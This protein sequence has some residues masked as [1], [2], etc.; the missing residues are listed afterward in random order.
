M[1][2]KVLLQDLSESL[3]RRRGMDKED[4]NVFVR[5]VFDI[6]AE[7]LQADKIIK[8]KGLGTFK[9]VTV[10][11]RESVDVNTGERIVIKEYTKVNFTPDPVLR[12]A[13]NKPFAQFET[14][15]LYEGTDV[16]E[17][18]RMDFPDEPELLEEDEEVGETEST[19]IANERLP[20]E[21][22]LAETEET[23][24]D[25]A[26]SGPAQVETE[27]AEEV[28]VNE[29]T[30]DSMSEPTEEADDIPVLGNPMD[31][32][33]EAEMDV[34]EQNNGKTEEELR[35]KE[36]QELSQVEPEKQEQ[37]IDSSAREAESAGE[38]P[39]ETKEDDKAQ[40]QDGMPLSSGEKTDDSPDDRQP[41]STTMHVATQQ[42]EV[43]KVEHQN[44]EHQHI[45]QMVPD[46][47]TRRIYLTPWMIFFVSLVVLVLMSFSYYLGYN[48]FFME[49]DNGD[50]KAVSAV[51]QN[52]K[53]QPVAAKTAVPDTVQ[54]KRD[55]LQASSAPE[56]GLSKESEKAEQK[57]PVEKNTPQTQLPQVKG[58]AYEIIGTREEHRLKRGETLREIAL[59][60]YG[61]KNFT[62]YLVTY[63]N[64]VNPD[65]VPEGMLLKI[66]ELKLKHR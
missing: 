50:A 26:K 32:M 13:V 11:S 59:R 7:Y 51:R 54:V 45:V 2:K 22:V 29:Q 14:V 63:N 42:I 65:L 9:L 27:V 16:A 46:S 8:V 3:V 33:E 34:Q 53:Q 23:A 55:T 10:D 18:E 58:G 28:V 62:V 57:Q 47:G 17:M 61:S 12:D 19:A 56:A 15:V 49:A 60:Y 25:E 35:S 37:K 36:V 6:I 66:P 1:N 41:Q 24:T 31:R 52:V 5:S 64:I 39:E 20:Q 48:R 44:V 38:K 21:N 4:A 30:A 43:Q 40:G